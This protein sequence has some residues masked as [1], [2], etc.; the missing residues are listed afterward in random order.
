MVTKEINSPRNRRLWLAESVSMF[1]VSFLSL[2][3]LVYVG[4][5]EGQRTYTG[6]LTAKMAAQ[7]EIV[8]NAMAG[9][10]RAGLPLRQFVGFQT[11]S[12]QIFE[13]DPTILAIVATDVSNK[14]V[15]SNH[16]TGNP[17]LLQFNAAQDSQVVEK[18]SGNERFEVRESADFIT[19]AL[20]LRSKFEVVG[21]LLVVMPRSI[22]KDAVGV[23]FV[24]L[25]GFVALLSCAF[26]WLVVFARNTNEA[27]K[28]R[29]QEIGLGACFLVTSAVVVAL[30][31]ALYT[32]GA[33][34]KAKALASSLRERVG[35]ISDSRI[36]LRDIDG[37][38]K[39]F[40]DYRVFNKDIESVGLL[41][42]DAYIIHTDPSKVGAVWRP[43]PGTFEY[44]VNL[45][46]DP[47]GNKQAVTVALPV[48]VV[49]KAIGNSVKNFIV[50]FFASGFLAAL[51][52]QL[53]NAIR[54]ISNAEGSDSEHALSAL[55]KVKP[56]L[57]LAVFVDNLS[58]SFLPQLIRGYADTAHAPPIMTSVAFMAYFICFAIVLVPA[59]KF[60]QRIGP[61]PLLWGG[62]LLIA[63]ALGIL[64]L[65]ENFN[66]LIIARILAGFGQGILFIGVQTL[67]LT[68]AS[69]SGNQTKM[70]G[71]IVYNFN[72]GMIS[73]MAIGS[74][75][76]LYMGTLG[77]FLFGFIA[78]VALTIYIV[79]AIP[80]V[81]AMKEVQVQRARG[82]FLKALK[83]FEFLRVMLLVGIPSKAVLTG[84][85]IFGLPILLSKMD[86]GSDEIGQ[87][88]MFYAVGVLLANF[89]VA[90]S[91][92]SAGRMLTGG[93]LMGSV[94]LM[95]IGLLGF[96]GPLWA[97]EHAV[98]M[99]IG[100]VLGV[101]AVGLGHGAINAPV[102][103]YVANTSLAQSA[104]VVNT[105][106]LYRVL[107]RVGH[108]LGP[109]VVGQL[110]AITGND[111]LLVGWIG[112]IL[113]VFTLLFQLGQEKIPARSMAQ[114]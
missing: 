61:K 113:L 69:T 14:V 46:D 11:L 24:P 5:G 21:G 91:S 62:A 109:M 8:Q 85:I 52:L 6:F 59:G 104:G 83:N 15:F 60:A 98:F 76:V 63:S 4:I 57:F 101:L 93:M 68:V 79:S 28:L 114:T 1:I 90:K 37:I 72:A 80:P 49:Y 17:S 75:L 100:L 99:S 38:D 39:A 102:V 32:D 22:V 26:S 89:L 40:S 16:K 23:A 94:G 97:M 36:D 42:G 13:S 112:V 33:Q 96:M 56:V 58:A 34:A 35:A 78:I 103:T 19:T 81:L 54:N 45:S 95:V 86:F 9:H 41:Q 87:I 111:I 2:L 82:G 20:P 77:V 64:V 51:V 47:H 53:A 110:L 84:V 31:V 106:S 43:S 67:V 48:D 29:R 66:L 25:V 70:N 12:A 7:G 65:T 107:E 55:E 18:V 30:L 10:L 73:G 88:I 105:T 27:K 50:L 71:I 74:L 92:V 3:L 44:K 108:V